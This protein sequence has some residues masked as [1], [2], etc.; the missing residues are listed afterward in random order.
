MHFTISSMYL[1]KYTRKCECACPSLLIFI[2]PANNELYFPY[3]GYIK[4]YILRSVSIFKIIE[5]II[6]YCILVMMESDGR[7]I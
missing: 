2:R 7:R 4:H 6:G 1:D 5:N 3:K